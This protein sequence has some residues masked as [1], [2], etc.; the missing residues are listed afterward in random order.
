MPTPL[1]FNE[2]PLRKRIA[3]LEN[4]VALQQ[5]E[6]LQLKTRLERVEKFSFSLASGL[7]RLQ[8]SFVKSFPN[9]SEAVREAVHD[10]GTHGPFPPRM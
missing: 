9:L 4:T 8:Q 10:A 3:D 2:P 1:F 7:S 6:I 5:S